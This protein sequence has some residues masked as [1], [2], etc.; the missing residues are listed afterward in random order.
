MFAADML[1]SQE[2]KISLLHAVQCQTKGLW[3][4]PKSGGGRE[5]LL[6]GGAGPRACHC[7]RVWCAPSN[8]SA[9][10]G[11]VHHSVAVSRSV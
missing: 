2:N 1:E 7:V 9:C 4:L 6:W 8:I 3:Y 10:D 11:W 5:L